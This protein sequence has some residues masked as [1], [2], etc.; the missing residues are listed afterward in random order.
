VLFSAYGKL[1]VQ[2]NHYKVGTPNETVN[3]LV[4]GSSDDWMYG[5]QTSKQKVY[6]MT[7]EVGSSGDGFWPASN[8]IITLSKEN[9]F[10]N[11]TT[12]KLAGRYGT[13]SHDEPHYISQLNN[14]FDFS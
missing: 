2:Y 13:L 7:P 3:Y 1:L 9:M 14:E 8:R 4:N 11:L 10:T 12:A 6:A 5:D